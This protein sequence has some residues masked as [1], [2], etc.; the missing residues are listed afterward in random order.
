MTTGVLVNQVTV[1]RQGQQLF[2]EVTIPADTAGIIGI[3]TSV[4]A[5][6]G[7]ISSTDAGRMAGR[8]KLQAENVANLCYNGEVI[9]GNSQL[10][11]SE[12]GFPAL[13]NPELTSLWTS[14]WSGGSFREPEILR[15]RGCSTLYGSYKDE[16][17]IRLGIDLT[18]TVTLYTWTERTE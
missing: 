7:I 10:E 9:I 18:Y 3:E 15:I 4:S 5:L 11:N 17:G 16:M 6:Q 13:T 12:A 2:F 8:L 14:P 1:N